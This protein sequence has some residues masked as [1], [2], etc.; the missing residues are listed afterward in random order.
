LAKSLEEFIAQDDTVRVVDAL[1][2]E[3]DM[4][5]PGFEGASTDTGRPSHP[6]GAAEGP[7]FQLD[8]S[9]PVQRPITTQ[10]PLQIAV[11]RQLLKELNS[12]CRPVAVFPGASADAQFVAEAGIGERVLYGRPGSRFMTASPSLQAIRFK[13]QSCHPHRLVF[14]NSCSHI[15]PDRTLAPVFALKTRGLQTTPTIGI[16]RC[17][18]FYITLTGRPF[19]CVKQLTVSSP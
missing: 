13:G 11:E 15:P 10:V 1:I 3:L 12:R 14:K 16:C 18:R 9:L 7:S 6:I 8:Q 5:A 19:A 4:V 17:G 2:G